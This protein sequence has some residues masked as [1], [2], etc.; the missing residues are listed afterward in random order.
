MAEVAVRGPREAIDA[1]VLAAPIG[2]DG[3][4]EADVGTVVAGDDALG[5][6]AMNLGLEGRKLAEAFPAVVERL[7]QLAL[8][9]AD[10]V[11]ARAAPAPPLSVHKR[12]RPD[13]AVVAGGGRRPAPGVGRLRAGL[14]RTLVWAWPSAESSAGLRTKKEQKPP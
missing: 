12:L 14:Q 7:A 9:A 4:V 3:L 10:A 6:L 13:A 5:R 2:V 8:E 11:G 1:A